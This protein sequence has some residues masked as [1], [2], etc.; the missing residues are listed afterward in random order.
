MVELVV[1]K[2]PFGGPGY[3]SIL[4]ELPVQLR[5]CA[6][7][8]ALL[9]ITFVEPFKQSRVHGYL[10]RFYLASKSPMA[11][12]LALVD[13]VFDHLLPPSRLPFM[14][15]ILVAVDCSPVRCLLGRAL[16]KQ[17]R[18]ISSTCIQHLP[19]GRYWLVP[20]APL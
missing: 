11:F 3:L 19:N 2:K 7:F 10:M 5:A 17:V 15:R 13:V 14:C 16:P 8:F 6:S 9:F 4:Q 12:S 18:A 1:S 20:E